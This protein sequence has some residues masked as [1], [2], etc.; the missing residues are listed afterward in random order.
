M[1]NT[2]TSTHQHWHVHVGQTQSAPIMTLMPSSQSNSR[3]S[4]GNRGKFQRL[5]IHWISFG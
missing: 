4:T 3:Y 5:A 1:N 2:F